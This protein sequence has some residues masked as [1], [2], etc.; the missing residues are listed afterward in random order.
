M[1]A[2]TQEPC[3]RVRAERGVPTDHELVWTNPHGDGSNLFVVECDT[4]GGYV[5]TY[6]LRR[7]REPAPCR[8]GPISPSSSRLGPALDEAE[9]EALDV[10]WGHWDGTF[11][12]AYGLPRAWLTSCA[13][14]GLRLE[15]L[16]MG[17]AS[18]DRVWRN[19]E[20]A[21]KERGYGLELEMDRELEPWIVGRRMPQGRY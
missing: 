21:C 8:A 12:E 14:L 11:D 19:L 18:C 5:Q 3:L 10:V 16:C 15:S 20:L 9:L 17:F 6:V 13:V 2:W 1:D 7:Y 4:R